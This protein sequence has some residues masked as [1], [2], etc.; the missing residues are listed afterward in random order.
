[1]SIKFS[2]DGGRE[3]DSEI[4]IKR[5]SRALEKTLHL[6]QTLTG[7]DS[8]SSGTSNQTPG[9]AGQA[10][11]QKHN[12]KNAQMSSEKTKRNKTIGII[13]GIILLVIVLG[14]LAFC[15]TRKYWMKTSSSSIELSQTGNKGSAAVPGN[16]SR[17]SI[18]VDSSHES[19]LDQPSS[20]GK[21]SVE[22]QKASAANPK[23]TGNTMVISEDV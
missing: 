2:E 10:S 12:N 4:G 19:N 22:V 18:S 17:E 5:T 23:R 16:E 1:M 14:L 15:L 21:P 8:S 20:Y 6:L 7:N 9:N 11:T 13:F 3:I